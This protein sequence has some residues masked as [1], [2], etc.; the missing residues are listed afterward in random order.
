[1]NYRYRKRPGFLP[2]F[3]LFWLISLPFPPAISASP[4]NPGQSYEAILAAYEAFV[5]QQMKKDHVPGLSVAFQHGDFFWA[6]GFGYADLENDVPASAES[7]YRLASITKTITAVAILLLYEE[8]KLDLDDEVQKYVPSFPRKPWPIT[9]RQLLGHLGGISHYRNYE[10]EGHIREPKTTEEAL[11]I[12]KDFPLVAEPGTRYNYSTY[13]YNLLGAVVEAA[14]GLPYGEFIKRYIFEPL[15]MKA[16]RLDSQTDLIPHRVRGYRLVANE[17]RPSEFID[18]S[19]RFAGGGARS[20]VIDLVHYGY[21]LIIQGELL[22]PETRRMMLSSMVQKNGFFTGYG[23]GWVVNP[24]HGHFYVNH[25]GSQQET[26]THLAIFPEEKL[27]IAIACNLEGTDLVPYTRKLAELIFQEKLEQPVYVT[28]LEA[29]LIWKACEL[30]FEYGLSQYY[31]NKGPL[32]SFSETELSFKA[33]NQNLNPRN[34]ARQRSSARQFVLTG[35]HPAGRQ[36]LTRIGSFMAASLSQNN[37]EKLKIY[38]QTGPLNFF[39]DYIKLSENRNQGRRLPDFDKEIKK[40]L[41][42]WL[43]DWPKNFRP[44]LT[45]LEFDP[46]INW[47]EFTLKLERN[48]L[49]TSIYP[50]FSSFYLRAAQE[51]LN[52]QKNQEA[53]RIL[54]LGLEIY[55][56]SPGL[57]SALG[58]A[59]FWTGDLA[60]GQKSLEQAWSYDPYSP[61][62]SVDRFLTWS[63]QLQRAKKIKEALVLVQ[64]GLKF[65]PREPR[66]YLESGRLHLLAGQRNLAIQALEKALSLDPN[67]E[68]A[69]LELEALKKK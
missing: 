4:D 10:V 68:E 22:K 40:L 60:N 55:P 33:F 20:T 31:W 41:E 43:L 19:S 47:D 37:P 44:E 65:Y 49:A 67:F 48:F 45:S 59:Y 35:I 38:H 69:R 25:S 15:G 34:I 29:G 2:F 13:G 36:H 18:V 21:K 64:T 1:M 24:W 39:L 16:S 9:I 50:D 53:L 23:L 62:I 30:A 66:L 61:A 7:A 5:T 3:F 17:I 26:R 14:S 46:A 52:S 27:V 54:K 63:G 11:A 42:S 58:L 51:A 56:L 8:G 6:K 12:F 57:H 28:S 32:A